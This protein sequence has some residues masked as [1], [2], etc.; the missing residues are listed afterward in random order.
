LLNLVFGLRIVLVSQSK[1]GTILEAEGKF[2]R[3]LT[4]VRKSR[5]QAIFLASFR[6]SIKMK[7]QALLTCPLGN[8][9]VRAAFQI[10]RVYTWDRN[11]I[12]IA[13]SPQWSLVRSFFGSPAWQ[14][15]GQIRDAENPNIAVQSPPISPPKKTQP[16]P[17]PF[18][19]SHKNAI[20]A[21]SSAKNLPLLYH[22]AANVSVVHVPAVEV[23]GTSLPPTESSR[24]RGPHHPLRGLGDVQEVIV[25]I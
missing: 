16:L 19:P 21:A 23:A 20:D 17:P 1:G 12:M 22:L 8:S 7:P 24:K 11:A 6:R 4:R 13:P 10:Y 25:Q 15:L 14:R 9:P 2:D 5:A 18:P 3:R